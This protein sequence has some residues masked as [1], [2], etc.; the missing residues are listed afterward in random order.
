MKKRVLSFILILATMLSLLPTLSFAADYTN[1][2]FGD[3]LYWSYDSSLR[4]LKITGNGEIPDYTEYTTPWRDIYYKI[5]HIVISEGVSAI[6]D[7]SFFSISSLRTITLPSTIKRV[8]QAAVRYDSGVTRKLYIPDLSKWLEIDFEAPLAYDGHLRLFV[9]GTA[10]NDLVIP[11][12][13]AEINSYA[14]A[15]FDSFNSVKLPSS[16]VSIGKDAFMGCAVYKVYTPSVEAWLNI[17]FESLYSNMLS[18]NGTGQPTD[19]YINGSKADT[20]NIPSGITQI[21]SYAFANSYITKVVMPDTVSKI[22]DSAFLNCKKLTIAN[23]PSGVTSIGKSAFSGCVLLESAYLPYGLQTLGEGAFRNCK[24]IKE[25]DIG[26]NIEKIEANVFSGC[27]ALQYVTVSE[28]ITEIGDGAFNGCKALCDFYFHDGL[29]KIGDDAFSGC[30]LFTSVILPDSVT[31]LG[32][33]A[34]NNCPAIKKVKI[35]NNITEIHDNTFG[36]ASLNAI[37]IPASVTYIGRNIVNEV[38]YVLFGG[39][40]AL[41][42]QLITEYDSHYPLRIAEW[43]YNQDGFSCQYRRP[44]DTVCFICGDTRPVGEPHNYATV[45]TYYTYHTYICSYC[46]K[47]DVSSRSVHSYNVTDCTVVTKCSVCEMTKPAGTHSYKASCSEECSVCHKSRGAQTHSYSAPCDTSCNVCDAV[48][49]AGEHTYINTCTDSCYYCNQKRIP[50]HQFGAYYSN[51]DATTKKDGTKSRV[52]SLCGDIETVTDIGSKLPKPQV[53]TNPFVDVK[54]KDFFY[55]ATLWAVSTGITT[56]TSKTTFSPKDPCTR[57]QV[58]TFLWRAAGS[59]EPKS[60]RMPFTDVGSK[61]FYRKAVLW[62]VEQ[63]ITSGTSATTFGPNETCTRAQIATFLWR[64]KGK[65]APT[66]SSMPFQDVP[67]KNFAYK[68]ILW[69]VENKITTGT[70]KTTFGPSEACIRGQIVTFLYRAYK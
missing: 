58:V 16:L 45:I 50:P 28:N 13:T 14:F 30:A 66:S 44:C 57:G 52:C 21:K 8:G 43:V 69:A 62:A 56:G 59:P 15:S 17:E 63:G 18:T 6:G 64:A 31:T 32:Q 68:A 29:E 38:N 40:E 60:S 11:E 48:R 53:L 9:N 55:D 2:S 22:G 33:G 54:K 42:N 34:F 35:S 7:Y 26:D 4:T 70:S 10:V 51:G 41:K 37:Y 24:K 12:G 5:D 65:P 49:T 23:I 27:E 47:E 61:A 20:V 1:E 46:G 3:G 36:K 25:I 67:T 19:F 39:N